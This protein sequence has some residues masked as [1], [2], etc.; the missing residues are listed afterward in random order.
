MFQ[1]SQLKQSK[2]FRPTSNGSTLDLLHEYFVLTL[3]LFPRRE[4]EVLAL[5]S[6]EKG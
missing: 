2:S 5:L 4:Q 1:S 3:A 6:K